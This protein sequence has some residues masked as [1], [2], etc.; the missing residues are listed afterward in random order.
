MLKILFFFATVL[1]IIAII[2]NSFFSPDNY[3]I[4]NYNYP[5]NEDNPEK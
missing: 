5:K 4:S 1:L 2:A 3:N